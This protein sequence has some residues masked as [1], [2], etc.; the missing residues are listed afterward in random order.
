[1]PE[2]T[3][4]E[5]HRIRIKQPGYFHKKSFRTISL[6][7]GIKAVIGCP[8]SQT[9]SAGKCRNGTQIQVLLFNK[10]KYSKESART[11]VKKHP[12]IKARRKR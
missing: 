4:E 12:K 6:G 3:T 11:W 5:Y 8:R 2:E 7:N 9:Y 1:M 10:E